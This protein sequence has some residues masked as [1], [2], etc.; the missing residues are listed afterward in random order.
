MCIQIL[1]GIKSRR[2]TLR[3][4]IQRIIL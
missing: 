3:P 4:L 2:A 1:S